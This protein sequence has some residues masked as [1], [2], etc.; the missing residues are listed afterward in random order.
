M[1]YQYSAG[2]GLVEDSGARA[3]AQTITKVTKVTTVRTILVDIT[4]TIIGKI[5]VN[6][7][8]F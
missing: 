8:G 7:R 3:T 4:R 1:L 6:L 5:G 2:G